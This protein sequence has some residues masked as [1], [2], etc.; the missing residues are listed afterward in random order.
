VFVF[1]LSCGF[2]FFLDS[3]AAD[4]SVL[5]CPNFGVVE[6]LVSVLFRC[7]FSLLL[8]TSD[9]PASP[10]PNLTKSDSHHQE[11]HH[12]QRDREGDRNQDYQGGEHQ[13]T[14]SA[15]FFVSISHFLCAFLSC[16]MIRC[17]REHILYRCDV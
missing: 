17:F 10:P 12:Q 13:N 9:Q 4:C 11:S 1:A 14:F 7:F 16:P 8:P 2:F 5:F 15:F 6:L 3:L